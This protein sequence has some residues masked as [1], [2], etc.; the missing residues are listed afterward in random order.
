MRNAYRVSLPSDD[1]N[2]SNDGHGGKD[3]C[4]GVVHRHIRVVCSTLVPSWRKVEE[5][6]RR[7]PEG[8]GGYLCGAR[9][10]RHR[11]TVLDW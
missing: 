7:W 6:A 8:D 2:D 11:C 1:I 10:L 4:L 5:E 3:E 9:L